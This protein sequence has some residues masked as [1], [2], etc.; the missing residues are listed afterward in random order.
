MFDLL[1]N[2]ISQSYIPWRN[3]RNMI[4]NRFRQLFKNSTIEES[5]HA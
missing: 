3:P 5:F 1:W 4:V 2:I